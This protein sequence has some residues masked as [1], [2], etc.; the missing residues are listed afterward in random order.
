[1]VIWPKKVEHNKPK[2]Q[3]QLQSFKF[4][5]NS[6]LNE[7]WNYKLKE[8]INFFE[9]IYKNGEK[10]KKLADVEVQKLN[11]LLTSCKE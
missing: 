5:S 9:S 8:N 10:K 7:V 4:T 11:G 1:M 6:N 3:Q 2:H